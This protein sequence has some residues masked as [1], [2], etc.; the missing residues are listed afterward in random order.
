M[1]Y[2]LLTTVVIK[3]KGE[4]ALGR[5]LK[6]GKSWCTVPQNFEA[7]LDW[8]VFISDLLTYRQRL[9]LNEMNNH[10]DWDVYTENIAEDY[11]EVNKN[12]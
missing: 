9:I 11:T 8:L 10:T 5:S 6:E 7:Y 1:S 2:N 4:R 3:S 12:G